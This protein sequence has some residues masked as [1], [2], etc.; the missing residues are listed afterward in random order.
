MTHRSGI[1]GRGRIGRNGQH[2]DCVTQ[3]RTPWALKQTIRFLLGGY[4][5]RVNNKDQQIDQ[6]KSNATRTHTHTLKNTFYDMTLCLH[7][8]DKWKPWINPEKSNKQSATWKQHNCEE[9]AH[10]NGHVECN[11]YTYMCIQIWKLER[12][13]AASAFKSWRG[14]N[15]HVDAAVK[16]MWYDLM[17]T[18]TPWQ[19]M[20][21]TTVAR[22]YLCLQCLNCIILFN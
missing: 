19:I 2:P 4:E 20:R 6:Q 15:A 18:K 11:K 16:T 9:Y 7:T 5:W 12:T 8:V 22:V 17:K 3:D 1:D 13:N 14:A 21:K 10:E